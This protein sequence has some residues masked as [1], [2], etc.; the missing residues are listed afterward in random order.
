M[1]SYSWSALWTKSLSREFVRTMYGHK[2]LMGSKWSYNF[3][4]TCDYNEE[5][6]RRISFLL[7]LR[8]TVLNVYIHAMRLRL[9]WAGVNFG[10]IFSLWDFVSGSPLGAS[11]IVITSSIAVAAHLPLVRSFVFIR[12]FVDNFIIGLMHYLMTNM[13]LADRYLWWPLIN[14]RSL[15]LRILSAVR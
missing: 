10:N 14:T 9:I 11:L 8:Q 12:S 4:F 2:G 5:W 1:M 6:Y 7:A 3:D 13:L 15:V